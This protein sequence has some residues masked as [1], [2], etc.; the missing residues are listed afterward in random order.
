MQMMIR[1]N[2]SS[3]YTKII[4][5]DPIHLYLL[6]THLRACRIEFIK[7][8]LPRFTSPLVFKGTPVSFYKKKKKKEPEYKTTTHL[9]HGI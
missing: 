4:S 1:L 2:L 9:G 8:V 5:D 7:H 3:H 6:V